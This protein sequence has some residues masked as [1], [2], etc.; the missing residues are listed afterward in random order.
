MEGLRYDDL[1][2][3]DDFKWFEIDFQTLEGML[4]SGSIDVGQENMLSFWTEMDN[5][6]QDFMGALQERRK[7]R[8]RITELQRRAANGDR[9]DR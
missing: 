4:P 6:Q 3:F 2:D 7:E 1:E 8:I 9:L 5:F